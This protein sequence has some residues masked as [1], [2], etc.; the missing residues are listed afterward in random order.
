MNEPL[1]YQR[2]GTSDVR[3]SSR[4]TW[5]AACLMRGVGTVL[6]CVAGL[7]VVSAFSG[8]RYLSHPDPVL[9]FVTNRFVLLGAALI[10]SLVACTALT[11]QR[12]FE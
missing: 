7:K 12:H 8:V 2:A 6:L 1:A 9:E 3:V 4:L 5:V 10:E 11:L